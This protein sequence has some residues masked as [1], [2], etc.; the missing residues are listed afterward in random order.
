MTRTYGQA[1]DEAIRRHLAAYPGADVYTA[2]VAE[3]ETHDNTFTVWLNAAHF[4]QRL[5]YDVEI[6]D[7]APLPDGDDLDR[8]WWDVIK[9]A[10][11]MGRA[12]SSEERRALCAHVDR[13]MP[14]VVA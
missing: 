8:A 2:Q 1:V 12:L 5:R 9:R 14:P 10:L 3:S 4:S 11:D 13:S 7:G 6:D